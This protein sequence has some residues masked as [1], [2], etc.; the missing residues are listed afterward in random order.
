[1]NLNCLL[2]GDEQVGKTT[3]SKHFSQTFIHKH[4]YTA[5]HG[6][7]IY[8]RM[9]PAASITLH[10]ISGSRTNLSSILD[11]IS[12]IILVYDEQNYATFL[13]LAKW[14][15][16][17]NRVYFT[18]GSGDALPGSS[19]SR[20]PLIAIFGNKTDLVSTP[21]VPH[22]ELKRFAEEIKASVFHVSA[23]AGSTSGI[24]EAFAEI[25]SNF[26]VIGKGAAISSKMRDVW[27]LQ[28]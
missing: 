19:H 13:S 5:T 10:D 16:R 6:L 14:V 17:I 20:L 28:I 3:I 2:L 22:L 15:K 26:T 4:T 24:N 23:Y 21:C 12:I 8:N 25:I 18:V 7:D 27:W 11:A 1:M 9:L